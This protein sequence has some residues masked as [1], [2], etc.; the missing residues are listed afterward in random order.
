MLG[1]LIC[2]LMNRS[3]SRP[4]RASHEEMIKHSEW[5][6]SDYFRAVGLTV[7]QGRG[8]TPEDSARV[9][10]RAPDCAAEAH[11][12]ELEPE[13]WPAI[14]SSRRRREVHLRSHDFWRATVDILRLHRERRMEAPPGFEPG[15]EVLQGHPRLFSRSLRF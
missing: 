11:S 10:L 5:V 13:I 14:R 9:Q 15:M 6:T 1:R 2:M 4:L 12:V 8:F 7:T 3:R